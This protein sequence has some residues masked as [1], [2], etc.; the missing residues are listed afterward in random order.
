MIHGEE[1]N[2]VQRAFVRF[3]LLL[4][5]VG[6]DCLGSQLTC[7]RVMSTEF[8]WDFG[9]STYLCVIL[10]ISESYDTIS[11]RCLWKRTTSSLPVFALQMQRKATRTA[12]VIID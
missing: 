11:Q 2:L 4:E 7:S 8:L 6:A 9:L 12:L 10:D 5:N 1:P 3:Y